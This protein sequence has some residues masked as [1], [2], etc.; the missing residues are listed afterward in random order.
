M[1]KMSH[2]SLASLE[3]PVENDVAS[4]WSGT[5]ALML[6]VLEDAI[7]NFGSSVRRVHDE[8]EAWIMSREHRYVFSFA[9][10]CETLH[11]DPSAVRRSL[12]RLLDEKRPGSHLLRRAR[13]NVRHREAI[14][15]HAARQRTA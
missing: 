3:I 8:A 11:L 6:A 4:P 15:L 14:Q 9:V 13:P 12:M 7:R 1:E 5:R 2:V 10:I